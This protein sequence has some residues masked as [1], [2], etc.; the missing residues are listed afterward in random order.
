LT[1]DLFSAITTYPAL[2]RKKGVDMQLSNYEIFL[3]LSRRK[4]EDYV[5]FPRPSEDP[6]DIKGWDQFDNGDKRAI[7]TALALTIGNNHN[8]NSIIHTCFKLL[9][10]PK[11][12][13][14]SKEE[15][16]KEAK[17]K[18]DE[19]LHS[20]NYGNTLIRWVMGAAR[21]GITFLWLYKS[22]EHGIVHVFNLPFQEVYWKTASE[23]EPERFFWNGPGTEIPPEDIV[24]I[25]TGVSTKILPYD[26]PI[27]LTE[28]RLLS[29]RNVFKSNI[30]AALKEIAKRQMIFWGY[31]DLF[32]DRLQIFLQPKNIMAYGGIESKEDSPY[33]LTFDGEE[34]PKP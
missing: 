29:V 10:L 13:N 17:Q 22:P 26:R 25:R 5:Y 11:E 23:T 19:F 28:S 27:S 16:E 14:V 7:L 12:Q 1:F 24:V 34:I 9:P 4:D 6:K 33:L 30:E 31:H 15:K 2:R 20:V 18:L 32:I 3:E 8:S 21:N